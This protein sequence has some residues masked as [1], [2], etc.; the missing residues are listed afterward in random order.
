MSEAHNAERVSD[1]RSVIVKLRYQDFRSECRSLHHNQMSGVPVYLGHQ[2]LI[3]KDE[4]F[5][6]LPDGYLNA[7]VMDKVPGEPVTY[8][9]LTATEADL[10]KNQLARMFDKMRRKA[11]DVGAPN[12]EHVFFDREAQQTYASVAA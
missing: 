9:R 12:T 6:Y 11:Y 8:L 10:I 2:E 7:L 5:R 3:Q 1:G 4:H